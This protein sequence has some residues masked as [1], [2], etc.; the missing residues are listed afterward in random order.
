MNETTGQGTITEIWAVLD[1]LSAASREHD[2]DRYRA[3]L[4]RAHTLGANTEQIVDAWTWGWRGPKGSGTP[5][6]FG[7]HGFTEREEAHARADLVWSRLQLD[8]EYAEP[9]AT[10]HQIVHDPTVTDLHAWEAVQ[11]LEAMARRLG[12][13]ECERRTGR[14]CA[15]LDE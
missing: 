14:P 5:P 2:Q 11:A 13:R 4:T 10:Q 15:C 12:A 1:A 7:W 3:A 9:A 8:E 6:R